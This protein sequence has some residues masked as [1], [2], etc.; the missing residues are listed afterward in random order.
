MG[1]ATRQALDAS[2]LRGV[3]V[4]WLKAVFYSAV[5]GLDDYVLGGFAVK[6]PDVTE[7]ASPYEGVI[8]PERMSEW[9][10]PGD[11]PRGSITLTLTTVCKVLDRDLH[12]WERELLGANRGHPQWS[13]A[14]MILGLNCMDDATRDWVVDARM[15][16]VPLNDW[17]VRYKGVIDAMRRCP[18]LAGSAA[19][20][21]AVLGLRKVLNC[22]WRDKTDADWEEQDRVRR[23]A[24]GGHSG[25]DGQGNLS[26]AMW[27][28]QLWPHIRSIV[29]RI[30]MAQANGTQLPTINEW[31]ASRWAWAPSGSTSLKGLFTE[32]QATDPRIK[33]S[34]RAGKKAAFEELGDDAPWRVLA[35]QPCDIARASTKPEPGGKQR[36]LF[37][38]SDESFIA[39]S[40]ASLHVEKHMN[41][42]G[43]VGKQTPADV[44]EWLVQSACTTAPAVWLSLDYSAYNEGHELADM[45]Q[46]DY[47]F[48][49]AWID[50]G[51]GTQASTERAAASLWVAQSHQ[52]A[53]ISKD[54]TH[55]RALGGLFSGHRNT[56]RDNSILHGAYSKA[57]VTMA[58]QFDPA[59]QPTYAVFCGDDEDARFAD[60][61]GALYYYTVHRLA[62]HAMKASKQMAGR[63]HEF[64]QRI[65]LHGQ[66][67]LR[68]L[69]AMLAQTASGNWYTDP[70]IWYELAPA[71]V[72]DNC[73]G[74]HVRG[75]PLLWAR[76]LA[77]ETLNAMMRLPNEEGG[78]TALEWW[79]YRNGSKPHPLWNGLGSELMAA[80][81]VMEKPIPHASVTAAASKAWVRRQRA[82]FSIQDPERWTEYEHECKRESYGRLY[83]DERLRSQKATASEVWPRRTSIL[84]RAHFRE[85]E[86]QPLA[87]Q[88]VYA[89]CAAQPG[90]RRPASQ[91]EVCSRFG[92]DGKLLALIGGWHELLVQLEPHEAALFE[93]PVDILPMHPTLYKTDDAITSW[94]KNTAAIA[95]AYRP[96]R[97]MPRVLEGDSDR[98][99]LTIWLAPNLAGKSTLVRKR[100]DVLDGDLLLQQREGWRY[101]LRLS[102][103]WTWSQDVAAM[104]DAVWAHCLRSKA[105]GI[106]W[107]VGPHT[108]LAPAA[109]RGFAVRVI[110]VDPGLHTLL[111]RGR[112][113]GWTDRH[114][115]ARYRKWQDAVH[116]PRWEALLTNE[117]KQQITYADHF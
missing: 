43:I 20:P 47:E 46:L 101:R 95:L 92:I 104:S 114:T 21:D 42:D 112:T 89:I 27:R 106:A 81:A 73:W 79:R 57:A 30:V 35:M 63:C 18:I 48:A 16:L 17:R 105:H 28:R 8:S 50:F 9:L 78:W 115:E 1:R 24:P 68:P 72:S 71:A 25:I 62:G 22:T 39:A 107:Q 4:A 93:N 66:H 67:P 32:L 11:V 98:A 58:T 90:D 31:W 96:A 94:A 6:P 69:W 55:T 23:L 59:A 70:H 64:L 38:S 60:W 87:A 3:D 65:F 102:R 85:G 29:Q 44:A 76:R 34:A 97:E 19:P 83:V 108:W 84:P 100:G 54:G 116:P 45:S 56:A 15:H 80:P 53:W 33:D 88:E 49:R 7:S 82:R 26:R 14:A 10:I 111:P 13:V 86:V 74:L 77:V 110:V 2:T 51:G 37:A 103:K 117:E 91:D 61:I 113:R 36:A 12:Q 109:Q 40:Y 5:A 41:I 75:M 52:N 99:W